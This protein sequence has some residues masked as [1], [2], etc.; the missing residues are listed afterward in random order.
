MVDD[1][2]LLMKMQLLGVNNCRHLGKI[3][4]CA[5]GVTKQPTYGKLYTLVTDRGIAC[6][7]VFVGTTC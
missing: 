1:K 7:F 3:Q 4:Q 6:S 2:W 5:R